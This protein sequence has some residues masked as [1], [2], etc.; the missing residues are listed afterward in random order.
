MDEKQSIINFLGG[1]IMKKAKAAVLTT[2]NQPFTVKEYEVTK[3][4][5]GYALLKL[6]ASGVCGTDL[7]FHKGKL[8]DIENKIIGHEFI[9]VVDDISAADSEKCGLKV[10]DIA[11]VYIACPCGECL[12]CKTG[13]EANCVNMA[14]T[15]GGNPDEAPHFHGGFAEYSYSPIDN[16]I[17]LPKDLEPI[18]ASV[19]ACPGPTALHAFAILKRAGFKLENI[20][21]AV[22]QGTGPVGCFA[23]MYLAAKGVKNVI[24][25]S[26]DITDRDLIKAL[27][28][29]E[30]I[31]LAEKSSEEIVSIIKDMT[32][33][34][35]ADLVYEASG[36][37]AAVAFGMELLRNRG[38]YLIPGQYSNSG[39]VE[40]HP[41]MITFKA[42]AMLGSSQY[43]K[44]DI[45]QYVSFLQENPHLHK[46]IRPLATCYKVDEVNKAFDDA[47]NRKNIKTV[48]VP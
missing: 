34:L 40:I 31:D 15:N 29:T 30:I 24:S 47:K 28:A 44:S 42:L 45:A 26:K 37:P 19:F 22:V 35:G 14:V 7:H 6:V 39:P 20:N 33:S 41:Q 38:V 23:I 1:V 3:P 32:G 25:I 10:G 5:N 16:L 13:D 36:N 12:L 9:G 4:S 11:M 21:T 18:M 48:F 2:I 27:G 17:L 46:V 43:D 8:G